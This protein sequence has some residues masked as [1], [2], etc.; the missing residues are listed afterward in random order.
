MRGGEGR[1]RRRR[2]GRHRRTAINVR[3]EECADCRPTPAGINQQIKNKQRLAWVEGDRDR[4]RGGL[5][6]LSRHTSG[7]VRI[8]Q[9]SGTYEAPARSV[10]Y[11]TEKKHLPQFV[12]L[13]T[14]GNRN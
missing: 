13:D 4:G 12:M 9:T 8:S 2:S 10:L 3:A 14:L 6:R 7:P 5:Q 1:P 11:Q